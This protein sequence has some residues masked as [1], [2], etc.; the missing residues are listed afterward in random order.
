MKILLMIFLVASNYFPYYQEN[1]DKLPY[2]QLNGVFIER[3]E[4]ISLEFVAYTVPDVNDEVTLTVEVN[5]NGV[6]DVYEKEYYNLKGEDMLQLDISNYIEEVDVHVIINNFFYPNELFEY[7]FT[8]SSLND[9]YYNANEK[10]LYSNNSYFCS[11]NIDMCK[12]HYLYFPYYKDTI[13]SDYLSQDYLD[14][15]KFFVDDFY[16]VSFGLIVEYDNNEYDID[17]ITS[18]R[19]GEYSLKPKKRLYYNSTL[20]ILEF[21]KTSDNYV[22]QGL[23]FPVKDE[24]HITLK[25]RGTINY[26]LG[27]TVV[28]SI[29]LLGSCE[30]ALFCFV[31]SK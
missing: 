11:F 8:I 5:S 6:I 3:G 4:R 9:G 26:N 28:P 12:D 30:E 17:L 23:N 21:S 19:N 18:K 24:L 29:D 25:V 27:L 31:I 15:F 2:T 13:F 1:A 20:N 7:S 22:I 16:D 14:Y 10:R